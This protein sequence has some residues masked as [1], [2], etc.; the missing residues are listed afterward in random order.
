MEK[1]NKRKANEKW[2][3]AVSRK[4][5]DSICAQIRRATSVTDEIDVKKM[6]EAFDEYIDKGEVSLCF[7]DVEHVAFVML[8]PYIDKAIAR[9]R[10]A[11]QAAARRRA[12]KTAAQQQECV[13]AVNAETAESNVADAAESLH[14]DSKRR[15]A[16]QA[17]RLDK[18][19]KRIERRCRMG[20]KMDSKH[21]DCG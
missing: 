1:V 17:R 18:H 4:F 8:Q 11:R 20:S 9:S 3:R 15:E 16:A 2:N 7:S 21:K 5:Y 10:C 13:V 19:R 14:P 6:I 12:A